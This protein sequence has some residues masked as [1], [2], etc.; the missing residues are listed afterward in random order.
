ML[1]IVS[2]FG[3]RGFALDCYRRNPCSGAGVTLDQLDGFVDGHGQMGVNVFLIQK[4][5][6]I[7]PVKPGAADGG[8]GEDFRPVLYEEQDCAV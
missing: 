6:P 8:V 2:W 1:W 5:R 4:S 3:E 7:L